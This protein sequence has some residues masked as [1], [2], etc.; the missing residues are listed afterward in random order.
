ME[1]IALT[2]DKK[3]DFENIVYFYMYLLLLNNFTNKNHIISKNFILFL[4]K[5]Q[6]LGGMDKFVFAPCLLL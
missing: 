6:K 1:I 5:S 2:G 3:S 4:E